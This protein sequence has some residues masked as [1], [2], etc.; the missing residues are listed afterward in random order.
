MT[1]LEELDRILTRKKTHKT[2]FMTLVLLCQAF[3]SLEEH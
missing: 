2:D 1:F 3:R